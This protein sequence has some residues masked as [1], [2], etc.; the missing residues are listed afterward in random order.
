MLA[1]VPCAVVCI[2]IYSKNKLVN[3]KIGGI[4]VAGS[5]IL[6]VVSALIAIK[7]ESK[8]LK[9]IFGVFI[10]GLGIVQFVCFLIKKLKEKNQKNKN[11]F[12]NI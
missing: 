7:I 5:I 9:I 4:I 2:I 10:A 3:Y 12:G 8:I 1:F 6:A 11:N